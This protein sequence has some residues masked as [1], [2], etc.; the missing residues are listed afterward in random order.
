MDTQSIEQKYKYMTAEESITAKEWAAGSSKQITV[1]EFVIREDSKGLTGEYATV[2]YAPA[3]WKIIDEPIVNALDH[4]IRCKGT[5]TPVTVIKVNF[6]KLGR[7]QIYNN[8]P[9]IEIVVHKEASEKLG[10]EMWLPTFLF[11]TLFQGSNREQPDDSIIGGTNGLGAKLANCFSTE[12]IVETVRDNMFFVQRWRNHKEI[13][14]PPKIVDLAGPHK[15]PKA[16]TIPHTQLSFSPDYTGLFGYENFGE[17]QYN[18]LVDIVRTRVIYAAAY[19]RYSTSVNIYFNDVLVQVNSISDIAKILFPQSQYISAI[20]NPTVKTLGGNYKYPWDVCAVVT[21]CNS[22]SCISIV[23]G[24]VVR[25]GKHIK[26]I[27]NDLTEGVKDKITKIFHDKDMKFSPSYVSNNIFLLLNTKVPKPSWTGQ[28]KDILDTDIRKFAGYK[29][30]A[31]FMTS[32]AELLQ[33]C[34]FD[35][36][37]GAKVATGRKKTKHTDYEKYTPAKYA[38]GKKSQLCYLI[39]VEGDSAMTQVSTGISHNLGFQHY[40]VISLGGVIMN[41]RKEIT[42]VEN[43]N[44]IHIKKSTKLTKNIFMNVLMEVTGLNIDYKYDPASTT[45]KKEMNEL[46]YG[47]LVACVDQDLDGKGN[48]LGLLLSTFEL[49]WPSLLNAGYVK[50]FGTPIIRAYPKSGG[51]I[52]PFY[53]TA[54]FLEWETTHPACKYNMQYYKGIGTHSRDETIHMFGKFHDHLVTYYMDERS[55]DLFEIYFG[56]KSDLRKIELAKPTKTISPESL[57]ECEIT[58]RMSCSDHLENDTN[59]YQKDNLERK[60]DHV[61][62]GQNQAGR[63]I[64]DGLIKAF[65]ARGNQQMKVNQLGGYVSEHENYH[66]GEASLHNSITGRGLVTTGGK[67]LPIIVPLSN[68]GSRKEGGGDAADAR[69]I[70][71]KLNKDI[72]E[73]LFPEEDYWILPF[74]FD[75]GK[76]SEPKYFVP[77]IPLAIIESTELPAHGWKLK[78]WGRDVFKV[79]ENVRRLIRL[80]DEVDLIPMPPATY[81]GSPYEW[82]GTI[83]SIRGDQYSF[84]CYTIDES[85]NMITITEL[86]LRVWT[87]P[88][89]N[90]LKKKFASINN[91]IIAEPPHDLS[92]DISVKIEIKLKPGALDILETYNDAYF[93][94]GIEEYFQLRDRMDSHINLMGVSGE[95]IEAKTYD[96][97]MYM[98]FP[99]RKVFYKERIDRKRA[100]LTYR[101]RYLTNIIRYVEIC[102]NLGLSKRKLSEMISILE[103]EKFDK[104][105]N[106]KL[107]QPKFTPTKDLESVIFSG[108]KSNYD[109]ILDLSD[110]KKSQESL[111]AYRRDIIA[112]EIELQNLDEIAGRGRFSGAEIFEQELDK[113]EAK[114]R[115]GLATFWKFGDANKYKL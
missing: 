49:F 6:D 20:V 25:D 57:R 55:H 114:I 68:F 82:R 30:D 1:K 56:T 7:V 115:A 92:D 106:G 23:N 34:I 27:L 89:V 93:T 21:S 97:I 19:A 35:S 91:K 103:E 26:H 9:G 69:Y 110:K 41:A 81:K 94:D 14:E 102:N 28:R 42:F 70:W 83:K 74:N 108:L 88:Y 2:K 80:G 48:I 12:F 17:E 104:I 62:D 53:S 15:I 58:K 31:K 52:I 61:I 36:M 86:P 90:S 29:L 37:F 101:I 77:I 51:Q 79:I 107:V 71:C 72:T 87:T 33:P 16:R 75:E 111:A 4:L 46:N 38:G 39:A 98:W 99:I 8:G 63:K 24:V 66:H 3:W 96:R 43:N 22:A 10:R 18:N 109:Y 78:T 95:I 44:R 65:R 76:R 54:E 5:P 32:I 64:L 13:E 59:L 112:V 40:G 47:H 45:Y 113:L 84:G 105:N 50:W 60:L 85:Q 100:L 11:G 73:L 67:Q